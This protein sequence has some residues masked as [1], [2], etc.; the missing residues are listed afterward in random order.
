MMMFS[1]LSLGETRL[2]DK[3]QCY[4]SFLSNIV[5]VVLASHV[6]ADFTL[7]RIGWT[8]IYLSNY[9]KIYLFTEKFEFL[10]MLYY[11]VI[12]FLTLKLSSSF[13]INEV[14]HISIH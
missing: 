10:K 2:Q 6:K 3:E 1:T 9:N 5:T 14:T 7:S 11:I 4:S 13:Y 8:Q 12:Y